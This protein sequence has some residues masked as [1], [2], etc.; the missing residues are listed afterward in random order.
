MIAKGQLAKSLE[1]GYRESEELEEGWVLRCME[2][3]KYGL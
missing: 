1:L 2:A 3:K